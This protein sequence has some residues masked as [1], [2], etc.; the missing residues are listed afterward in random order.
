MSPEEPGREVI[1]AWLTPALAALGAVCAAALGALAHWAASR[2]VGKA[3][4]QQAINSGFQGLVD[5]MET[6][7]K[8]A[9]EAHAQQLAAI[10]DM[11][12]R[13][14]LLWATRQAQMQGD[15]I[16]LRQAF[17]SLKAHLSRRGIQIPASF[18]RGEIEDVIVIE[19]TAVKDDEE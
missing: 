11:H 3:A 10:A 5:R 2:L 15:M 14:R 12:E 18:R 13:E 1:A 17:E 19:A 7:R 8:A 9:A 4:W 6:E 16:N